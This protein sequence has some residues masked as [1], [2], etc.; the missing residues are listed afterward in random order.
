[1]L[2]TIQTQLFFN[3]TSRVILVAI[4]HTVVIMSNVISSFL[5]GIGFEY[6]RKSAQQIESGIDSIKSKALQLGAVVAG[7]FGLKE[8]TFGYVSEID[9]LGKFGQVYSV[10][11]EDVRSLGYALGE[12]GGSLADAMSQLEKLERFR[13]VLLTGDASIFASFGIAKGDANDIINAKDALEAYRLVAAQF[14][15]ASPEERIN[16]TD[17]LG[18]DQSGLLLL[19]KGTGEVDRLLEKYRTIAPITKKMTDDAAEFT[20]QWTEA[21]AN[22]GSFADAISKELLP[23][24]NDITK[25]VNSWFSTERMEIFKTTGAITRGILGTATSNDAALIADKLHQADVAAGLAEGPRRYSYP[26]PNNS[27]IPDWVSD[28]FRT[29]FPELFNSDTAPTP[30][31]YMQQ[32]EE[33]APSWLYRQTPASPLMPEDQP[34]PM[35]QRSSSSTQNINVSLNLDGAVIDRRVVRVVDG[36]AQTA[37]DDISSSTRG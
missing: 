11:A 7:A 3:I 16:M 2:S 30:N 8:L 24:I 35:S 36:M 10:A 21:K 5:V 20:R 26:V 27:F 18:F 9:K 19:S 29:V 32:I 12:S 4:T 31:P 25:S 17:A 33:P 13:A 22:V 14:E 37:I 28:P 34:P 6:D 1:M 15:R 23:V